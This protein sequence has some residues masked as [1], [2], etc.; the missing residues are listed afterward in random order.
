MGSVSLIN[1]AVVALGL[2]L[3][4]FIAYRAWLIHTEAQDLSSYL[5]NE[6]RL[7]Q[8]A[9]EGWAGGFGSV[10]VVCRKT[11]ANHLLV[12]WRM[13]CRSEPGVCEYPASV[14]K[15]WPATGTTDDP[16]GPKQDLP[17]SVSL[18]FE[19]E[20][21]AV[22]LTPVNLSDMSIGRREHGEI[23]ISRRL[24]EQTIGSFIDRMVKSTGRFTIN[25]GQEAEWFYLNSLANTPERF[26]QVCSRG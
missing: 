26:K 13:P 2:A 8:I 9:D 17:Q 20:D 4:L 7:V 14:D 19:A 5:G 24:G 10:N 15:T 22:K 6:E 25:V 23:L 18:V 1:Q 3:G 11:K 21:D 16:A 12:F